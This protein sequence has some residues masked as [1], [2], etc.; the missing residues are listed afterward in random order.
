MNKI[1]EPTILSRR[2]GQIPVPI[3]LDLF[4]NRDHYL[5]HYWNKDE[6]EKHVKP[7]KRNY[8]RNA[9]ILAFRSIDYLQKVSVFEETTLRL[10]SFREYIFPQN[11]REIPIC[12]QVL[13]FV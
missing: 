13:G 7:A 1:T 4:A 10:Y 9:L 5:I 6:G 12:D 11:G 3:F 8:K 2:S